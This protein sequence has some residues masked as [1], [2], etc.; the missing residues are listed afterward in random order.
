MF[1]DE[2]RFGR[3][4]NPR[5]CRAPPGVRPSVP[6][7]MVREYTYAY[8]AVAPAEGIPDS[9]VLPVVNAQAMSLFLFEVSQRHPDDFILMVMDKAGRHQA[10]DLK[11]PKNMRIIFLPPYSPELNPVEH[12]REEIR[13][14]R[15]PNRVFKSLDAVEKVLV[16]ALHSLEQSPEGIAGIT[17]FNWINDLILK[18]T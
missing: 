7:H 1:Q 2:A 13:E 17:G 15:F 9:F 12:L 6:C 5:N 10:K 4:N 18:A 3:T 14:K 11:V 16:G 8:A